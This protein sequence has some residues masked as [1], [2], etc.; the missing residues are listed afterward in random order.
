MSLC[1]GSRIAARRVMMVRHPAQQQKRSIVDYLTNYPDKVRIIYLFSTFSFFP[2]LVSPF[3]PNW[4]KERKAKHGV[5]F[6]RIVISVWKIYQLFSFLINGLLLPF[7]VIH[8]IIVC[9]YIYHRYF[10]F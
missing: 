10:I 6:P 1:S 9:F 7:L 8:F 5:H 2:F 3:V 4:K